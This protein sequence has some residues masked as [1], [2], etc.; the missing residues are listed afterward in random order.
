MGLDQARV[1]GRYDSSVIES[2]KRHAGKIAAS[3]AALAVGLGAVVA[4]QAVMLHTQGWRIQLGTL[5]DWISSVATSGGFLA[6][7]GAV[8]YAARQW[9]STQSERRTREG[10]QARLIVIQPNDSDNIHDESVVVRNHSSAPIY[11][12]MVFTMSRYFRPAAEPHV[13]VVRFLDDIADQTEAYAAVLPPGSTT[14]PALDVNP[15]DREEHAGSI[16]FVA[17]TFT[18]AHSRRWWRFGRD[19]PTLAGAEWAVH[20]S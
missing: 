19:E 9:R 8:L 10:D 17:V 16:S 6:A 20:S 14:V 13:D 5:P 1:R 18:D 2:W 7:V 11:D 12:V 3:M 4:V 15:V